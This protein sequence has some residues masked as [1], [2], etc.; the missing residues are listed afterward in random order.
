VIATRR[1]VLE[2]GAEHIAPKAERVVAVDVRAVAFA[3]TFTCDRHQAQAACAGRE[4][5]A[6]AVA[7]HPRFER[8]LRKAERGIDR[9][10]CV[11]VHSVKRDRATASLF[12]TREGRLIIVIATTGIAATRSRDQR[13]DDTHSKQRHAAPTSNSRTAEKA[14]THA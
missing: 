12:G 5:R 7:T 1:H 13:H 2:V 9:R 8:E 11:I 4:R 3:E 10:L 6:F 14:R